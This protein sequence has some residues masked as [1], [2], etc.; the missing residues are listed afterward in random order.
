MF[1]VVGCFVGKNHP[2]FVVVV[3]D[4]IE[5]PLYAKDD[6]F[7]RTLTDTSTTRVTSR[8]SCGETI[9][10]LTK[11]QVLA[12]GKALLGNLIADPTVL[13]RSL[14]IIFLPVQYDVDVVKVCASCESLALWYI[15]R[16]NLQ[17]PGYHSTY[18]D[19]LNQPLSYSQSLSSLVLLPR[20]PNDSNRLPTGVKLRTFLSLPPTRIDVQAAPSVDFPSQF[21]NN[22]N[23]YTMEFLTTYLPGMVAASAGAIAL[24]PDYPG[25]G[26]SAGAN[27]IFRTIFRLHSYEQATA[28]SYLG[29]QQYVGNVTGECTQLDKA[30]TIHGTEDGA[31]G[32]V[33]AT[34]VL[35][36]FQI[37]SL[38]TFLQA[39]PLDLQILLQDTVAKYDHAFG[40]I[41]NTT[42]TNS[43]SVQTLD[44]WIQLALY[45][46]S[47]D[48]PGSSNATNLV[49]DQYKTALLNALG[50]PS[51]SVTDNTTATLPANVV[52]L[53]NP[54]FLTLL[55]EYN[56]TDISPC[57]AT[58]QYANDTTSASVSNTSGV[59]LDDLGVCSA[60]VQTSVLPLLLSLTDKQWIYNVSVCYSR[61]DEI[62]S[63]RHY[64][65][66][67]LVNDVSLQSLL[68]RYRGPL[69][70][71]AL[72]VTG[73]HARTL[74]LCAIDPLLFFT[75][76]G[77]QPDNVEDRGNY[78]PVLSSSQM[79]QCV[80]V[81]VQPTL[82]PIGS[83]TTS[84]QPTSSPPP[85]KSPSSV[86]ALTPSPSSS[87]SSSN[88]S[89]SPSTNNSPTSNNT[90][91]M[92]P[93]SLENQST[94]N[95]TSPTTNTSS[96]P[97]D[98]KNASNTKSGVG[99][100]QQHAVS[101]IL[102]L[103]TTTISVLTCFLGL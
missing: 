82:P 86:V 31:F 23:N 55:R 92:T 70:F 38:S 10:V 49:A 29:L 12:A 46:L 14:D 16:G 33:A 75:L 66:P 4:S 83:P 76:Q 101:N 63:P 20:D 42:T 90:N 26:E 25:T 19:Q 30:V 93:T 32:A 13:Q 53:L 98:Q 91:G 99:T 56:A 39:G 1:L 59:V 57:N 35:Q 60:I 51:S 40:V 15:A 45:T 28:V 67:D 80:P 94:A 2:W 78:M 3:G 22:N 100:A 97:P 36:R 71:G 27:G 44:E 17:F 18:C 81:V 95:G 62:V 96:S 9:G 87:N 47:V 34:L 61:D 64:L 85:T 21:N 52:D 8:A 88:N 79:A 5:T 50:T 43:T 24:F 68:T 7:E 74:Q 37:R 77:Y 65:Y 102:W 72:A 103:V 89:T 11:S 84:P 73:D 58:L 48:I 54:E 6:A 41:T 69:G